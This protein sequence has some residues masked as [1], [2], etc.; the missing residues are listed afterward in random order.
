M[1]DISIKLKKA[2]LEGN[3]TQEAVAEKVGVTRQTISNWE[4]GKSYPDIVSIIILSDVYEM[5]L[6][7][8]LKG[9]D[10]MIKHLKE[11]TNVTKSNKQLVLSFLL[12]GVLSVVFILIRIFVPIP[13]ITG[14]I[15]SIIAM[16]IFAVGIIIVLVGSINIQKLA[17]QHTSNKTLLKIGF[18]LLYILIY[19]P[20]FIVIPGAILSG[21]EI[22]AEWLNAMTRVG[23]A[24]ILLLP[25]CLIYRKLRSL[26]S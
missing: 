2:R 21:F 20:L 10:D 17:E 3:L 24:M 15:P 18:I 26:F 16:T 9:D 23:T 11:S 4:N 22:K 5:T 25:A 1:M 13:T 12:A 8:L 7:S 6:D 14:I 19:I